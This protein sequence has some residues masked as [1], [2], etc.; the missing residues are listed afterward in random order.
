MKKM[1]NDYATRISKLDVDKLYRYPKIL[2]ILFILQIIFSLTYMVLDI[3]KNNFM[4]TTKSFIAFLICIFFESVGLF[5]SLIFRN[6]PVKILNDNINFKK[7]INYYK[8]AAN[9]SMKS[10]QALN[11]INYL[12]AISQVSFYKGEFENSLLNLEQISLNGISFAK[13]FN[14]QLALLYFQILSLVYVN[15]K[16][17]VP[18]KLESLNRLYPQSNSQRIKQKKV[19]KILQAIE[20]IVINQVNNDYFDTAEPKNRL[21]RITYTY[22]AA[23]NAQLKGEEARTRELFESIAQENPE[24]FYVQEA[25]RYLKGEQ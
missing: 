25:K 18:E 21:S 12:L 15:K 2:Y 20:D 4:L 17:E 1:L 22:Y 3:I 8:F 10:Q 14:I 16:E 6:A 24:L 13:K 7:Y 5:N 19:L 9:H 11:N 23:L